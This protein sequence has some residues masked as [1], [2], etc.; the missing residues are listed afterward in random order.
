MAVA[1]ERWATRIGLVLALAGNAIGLGNFLRFPRQAALN[2]GGAFLMPYFVCL[3]AIGIPLMWVELAIG[4]LGGRHGRGH[5][6]GHVRAAVAPPAGEVRRRARALH[7]V[8]G[9]ARTTCSSSRGASRTRSSRSPAATSGSARSPRSA[10]SSPASRASS[11]TQHFSSL[12]A[13]VRVLR[14][15]LR[16][17]PRDPARRRRAR[18]RAA[19]ASRD[20]AALRVRG[21]P[22]GAR[23][24]ARSAAGRRRPTRPCCRASASSGIRDFARSPTRRCG[25]PRRARSSSRSSVGWGITPH[26]CVV[27]RTAT[28]TSRSTG[29]STVDA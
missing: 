28:T 24:D 4:R 22:D 15:R 21:D 3:L 10:T 29:L 12:A 9:R 5:T 26:L 25:S 16:A 27:H 8:R 13:R 18:D 2:G 17:E 6:A 23:A 19:G 11:R 7:P 20:A 1:R 14:A